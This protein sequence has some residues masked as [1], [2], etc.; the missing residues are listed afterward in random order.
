MHFLSGDSFALWCL[1]W[2]ILAKG[3]CC[4][5][6]IF[7]WKAGHQVPS[8]HC[9]DVASA[10]YWPPESQALVGSSPG[11]LCCAAVAVSPAALHCGHTSK[12]VTH[13]YCSSLADGE[14]YLNFIRIKINVVTCYVSVV[15]IS[16]Y[17]KLLL[18]SFKFLPTSSLDW[19]Q[20]FLS[21]LLAW[22]SRPPGVPD[23]QF[24]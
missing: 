19:N 12:T 10:C 21:K 24:V 5:F 9:A 2:D 22:Q 3:F 11:Q 15:T 18:C 13:G 20:I 6:G 17:F 14:A 23:P 7:L 8:S 16:S 4:C 1:L